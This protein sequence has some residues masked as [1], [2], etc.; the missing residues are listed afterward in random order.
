MTVLL[1]DDPAE[2]AAVAP[3]PRRPVVREAAAP[4][5]AHRIVSVLISRLRLRAGVPSTPS[6]WVHA[7]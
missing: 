7:G 4:E 5:A 6:L 3:G 1:G 2:I